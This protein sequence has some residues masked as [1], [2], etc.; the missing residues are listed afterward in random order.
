MFS[1]NANNIA[2]WWKNTV[3]KANEICY[4]HIQRLGFFG[5]SDRDNAS[6]TGSAFQMSSKLGN[7]LYYQ[8]HNI[9]KEDV[10]DINAGGTAG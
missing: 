6:W 4:N 5:K 3:D 7:T 2:I 10:F 1:N 8:K 9:L